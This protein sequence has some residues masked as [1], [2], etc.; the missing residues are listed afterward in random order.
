MSLAL[1]S[2]SR[3]CSDVD[4]PESMSAMAQSLTS[5]Q[6]KSFSVKMQHKL[7]SNVDVNL[8]I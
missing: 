6:Y 2:G 7:R 1:F 4:I 8:G 3:G 5:P